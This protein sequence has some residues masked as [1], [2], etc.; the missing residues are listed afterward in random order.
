MGQASPGQIGMGRLSM[1][2][3]WTMWAQR[4]RFGKGW[5]SMKQRTCPQLSLV[6]WQVMI[7]RAWERFS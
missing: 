2:Q 7:G 4:G 6:V 3:V 5:L 1:P